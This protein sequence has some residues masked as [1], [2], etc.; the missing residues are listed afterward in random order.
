MHTCCPSCASVYAFSKVRWR[1]LRYVKSAI[2]PFYTGNGR[3]PSTSR[4]GRLTRACS[5]YSLNR[6]ARTLHWLVEGDRSAPGPLLRQR[7]NSHPTSSL[8]DLEVISDGCTSASCHDHLQSC[9]RHPIRCTAFRW[10]PSKAT[11]ARQF[12]H[13]GASSDSTMG[14]CRA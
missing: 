3:H 2:R 13:F 1:P 5:S 9:D 14:W 6:S 7:V 4:R 10:Q 11:L 8:V 12:T